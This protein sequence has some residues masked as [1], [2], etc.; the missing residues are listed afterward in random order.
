[1]SSKPTRAAPP[2]ILVVE[3]F[4]L[5]RA[6]V[7][8]WLQLRFPGCTVEGVDSGERALE[9]ASTA[10]LDVVVMDINLPGIDGLKAARRLKEKA[11]ETAVV[12]LTTYDTPWHRR[13]AERA[14][15]AGFVAKRDMEAQLEATVL[16]A[17]HLDARKSS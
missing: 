7:V 13:A 12:M 2:S 4:D 14:G 1:M 8:R 9:H 5:L 10:R 15:A 11:P 16:G 3:D 6:S 17:L